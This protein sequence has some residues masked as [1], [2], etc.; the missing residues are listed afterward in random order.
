MIAR[1]SAAAG[2]KAWDST[3]DAE[4]AH[5]RAR[6]RTVPTTGGGRGTREKN[7]NS[8]EADRVAEPPRLALPCLALPCSSAEQP[9]HGAMGRLVVAPRVPQWMPNMEVLG[10]ATLAL[11][12]ACGELEAT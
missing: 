1:H 8:R 7:S 4:I 5:V 6:G 10:C 12:A 9:C 11:V 3:S 2:E